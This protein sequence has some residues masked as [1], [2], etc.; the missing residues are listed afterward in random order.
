VSSAG[1]PVEPY[2]GPVAILVDAMS[3]ST[4]EFFAGGMQAIGRAHVFGEA[5]AGQALPAVVSRLPNQ[6]VLMY[7][8]ADYVGP[9]G[10]RIE[11]RGVLPDVL[12]TLRRD[13]LLA[14]RD[15][16]LDA[17]LRW[18]AAGAENGWRPAVPARASAPSH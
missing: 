13:D 3:A 10:R 16:V 8:I 4:S 6:D 14:G 11:G 18:L 17:A 9:D 12:V 5:T 2:H 7:V 15:P 1:Q